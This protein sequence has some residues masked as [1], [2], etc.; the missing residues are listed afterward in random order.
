MND[1]TGYSVAAAGDVN[2]DGFDDVLLGTRLIGGGYGGA[3]VIYGKAGGFAGTTSLAALQQGEGF[4]IT[5]TLGYRVSG[6]GDVNGDGLDDVIIGA[7]DFNRAYAVFGFDTG[8]ITHRGDAGANTLTGDANANVIVAGQGDDILIGNGGADVLRGGQ[9]DD[10]HAISD[11][12]FQRIHGGNGTDTLRLDGAGFALNLTTLPDTKLQG[13]ERIDLTGSGAN[14]LTLNVREVLNLSPTSNTLTVLGDADDFV[15]FGSGWTRIGTEMILG[16]TFTVFTEGAA[17]LEVAEAVST[18]LPLGYALGGLE[19]QSRFQAQRGFLHYRHLRE[20]RRRREWRWLR[21]RDRRRLRCQ[22]GLRRLW[23]SGRVHRGVR[24]RYARWRQGFPSMA[25]RGQ[26]GPF[27]E[28]GGRRERRRV[29][30]RDRRGPGSTARTARMPARP[31]SFL[32]GAT[33]FPRT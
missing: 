30:G 13:I 27:F 33:D 8:A 14:T 24:S 23:Q 32:E 25:G 9:G 15:N 22:R 11:L 26:L 20:F 28:R 12:S 29:R 21:R 17:T 31:T 6:A 3:Y 5:G 10:V 1:A 2:G 16:A 7:R 18:S 4:P 19:G